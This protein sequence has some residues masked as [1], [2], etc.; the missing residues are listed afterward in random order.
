MQDKL[1]T[2]LLNN[3]TISAACGTRVDWNVRPS[4]TLP[5]ITLTLV[6]DPRPSHMGGLQATRQSRVQVD[7]WAAKY[8]Q[9]P[10]LRE[11]VITTLEP[12]ATVS[13]QV[14]LAGFPVRLSEDYDN[15]TADPIHR[16]SVDILV[17]HVSP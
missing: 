5:A 8:S 17:H 7:I 9:I 4:K 11:A 13:G 2:R 12:P 16:C 6:S 1:R 15:T 14:F 3:A 10:A